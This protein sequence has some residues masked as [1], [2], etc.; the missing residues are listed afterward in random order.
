LTIYLLLS[1]I[2]KPKKI[3]FHL[4]KHLQISPLFLIFNLAT[5]RINEVFLQ[6][7][8]IRFKRLCYLI[9][10]RFDE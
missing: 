8:L 9:A 5:G 3:I 1:F 2:Q 6:T 4:P 7:M 10:L